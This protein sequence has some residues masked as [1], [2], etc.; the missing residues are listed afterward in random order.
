[1]KLMHPDPTHFPGTILCYDKAMEESKVQH[2]QPS[3]ENSSSS[4]L[5]TV[6]LKFSVPWG[7]I[8][9]ILSALLQ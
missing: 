6:E 4:V 9:G 2:L 7:H 1:M 8:A 3:E 5:H